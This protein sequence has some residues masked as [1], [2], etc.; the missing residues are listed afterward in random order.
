MLI[1]DS[2]IRYSLWF[3]FFLGF[4]IVLYQLQ[5]IQQTSTKFNKLIKKQLNSKKGSSSFIYNYIERLIT[6]TFNIKSPFVVKTFIFS[7]CILSLITFIG[8]V[9]S[10]KNLIQSLIWSLVTPLFPIGFLL[11][12]RRANRINTS[13]EG[14]RFVQE[15]LNNYRIFH[16]NISEALD[17][18][19]RNSNGFPSSKKVLLRLAVGIKEYQTEDELE[20]LILELKQS[21]DTTWAMLL[22]NSIYNATLY[23]DNIQEG[24]IDIIDQLRDLENLNEKNKQT[25]MEGMMLLRLFIP[26]TILG[27][28]YALFKY[29]GFT[30]KKFIEYQFINSIGF[31]MFFYS[32]ILIAF[33]FLLS[34]YFKKEKNDY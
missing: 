7:L 31:T 3:T 4:W 6:S 10:D 34:L 9:N 16:F 12:K 20:E 30:F 14:I 25:N 21:I 15:L 17:H 18:T 8:L 26:F 29:F 24:L 32:A 22:G 1:Y 23:G 13:H 28:F 27:T 19:V 2:I 11:Y 5:P 33:T